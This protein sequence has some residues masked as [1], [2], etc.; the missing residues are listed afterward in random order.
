MGE[1]VHIVLSLIPIHP[2]PASICVRRRLKGSGMRNAKH[3]ALALWTVTAA[4]AAAPTASAAA[5]DGAQVTDTNTCTSD[6]VF[7][8]TLCVQEHSV[9]NQTTTPAGLSTGSSM[10]RIHAVSTTIST[11]CVSSGDT[12]FSGH[13]VDVHDINFVARTTLRSVDTF[14]CPGLT[15]FDCTFTLRFVVVGGV[16]KLDRIDNVCT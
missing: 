7:G 13:F 3:W 16:V 2:Q 12:T 15:L 1:R 10:G 14:V 5:S 9:F 4:L 11:G 8:T 6:P